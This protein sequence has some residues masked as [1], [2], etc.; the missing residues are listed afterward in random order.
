MTWY[1]ES[2]YRKDK[3]KMFFFLYDI[4]VLRLWLETGGSKPTTK[5]PEYGFDRYSN[6]SRSFIKRS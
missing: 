5:D 2:L 6:G 1:E 3:F 4:D